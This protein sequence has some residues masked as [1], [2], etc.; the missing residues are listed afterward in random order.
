[1]ND[2]ETIRL[3]WI[4]ILALMA[5]GGLVSF[6]CVFMALELSIYPISCSSFHSRS[7][8]SHY[9]KD[10]PQLDRNKDR[11]ACNNLR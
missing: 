3:Y 8:A 2:Y 11:V 10:Y 1:M 5:Y 6:I 9:L 7:E 4:T